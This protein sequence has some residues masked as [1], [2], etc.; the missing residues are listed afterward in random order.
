[1]LMKPGLGWAAACAGGGGQLPSSSLLLPRTLP[2]PSSIVKHVVV[3][4]GGNEASLYYRGAGDAAYVIIPAVTPNMAP[5]APV[6]ESSLATKEASK[7]PKGSESPEKVPAKRAAGGATTPLLHDATRDLLDC[8]TALALL[9]RYCSTALV[10]S[11][12]QGAAGCPKWRRRAGASGA[13]LRAA[14][15][16]GRSR[17]ASTAGEG[18]P[19]ESDTGG[20]E[21]R[22][23][24]RAGSQRG[25]APR[26]AVNPRLTRGSRA[27]RGNLLLDCYTYSTTTTTIYHYPFLLYCYC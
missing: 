9:L 25:V 16:R 1:M 14:G 11:S 19:G 23:F 22:G 15:R 17:R 12:S 7:A 18:A 13:G 24:P 3:C 26:G 21:E 10:F 2:R 20:A 4:R 8:S 27:R 5:K 6:D